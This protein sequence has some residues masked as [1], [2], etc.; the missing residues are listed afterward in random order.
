[1]HDEIFDCYLSL[2]RRLVRTVSA[3]DRHRHDAADDVKLRW[4][5]YAD[6]QSQAFW[7]LSDPAA[8]SVTSRG[9]DNRQEAVVTAKDV[10]K[11]PSCERRVLQ[12]A[13]TLP[14]HF[15]RLLF[16]ILT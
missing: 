14:G 5:E 12:E 10:S 11:P 4:A 9:R 8:V 7:C 6:R 13:R 3:A 16:H 15:K 1:M 2:L